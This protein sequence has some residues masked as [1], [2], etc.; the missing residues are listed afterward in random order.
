MCRK[1]DEPA[2]MAAV[3]SLLYVSD[4]PA[5]FSVSPFSVL[6]SEPD[7]TQKESKKANANSE[8]DFIDKRKSRQRE[9]GEE[10]AVNT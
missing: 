7:T 2:P 8:M 3:M 6:D 5:S 10:A 9:R 1:I 4:F